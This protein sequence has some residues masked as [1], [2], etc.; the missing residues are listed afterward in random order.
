MSPGQC[1]GFLEIMI[2]KRRARTTTFSS[3]LGICI[4]VYQDSKY[5]ELYSVPSYALVFDYY[6]QYINI[7]YTY[8]YL[9]NTKT[10]VLLRSII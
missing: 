10:Y 8:I 1:H 3:I 2:T 5:R 9:R 6:I 4:Y 7:L